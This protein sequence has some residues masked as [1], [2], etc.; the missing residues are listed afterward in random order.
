MNHPTPQNDLLDALQQHLGERGLLQDAASMDR[1][2]SDWAG[3]RLGLP[4]AVARPASTAEVAETVRL[5]QAHGVAMTP[6]VAT[7][8]WWPAPCPPPTAASW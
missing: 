4:L 3:D 2:L 6:R 7:A 8:A 1:Y 5:C